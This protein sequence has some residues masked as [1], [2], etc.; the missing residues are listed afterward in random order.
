MSGYTPIKYPEFAKSDWDMS[1]SVSAKR[2]SLS[3]PAKR[4]TLG[5]LSGWQVYDIH[6][7]SFIEG[8]YNGI[9]AAAQAYDANLL[10][11]CGIAQLSPADHPPI[12]IP[13][14]PEAHDDTTFV[15]V[16]RWNTD[17]MIII[18]P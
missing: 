3:G 7:N 6:L 10:F 4:L 8:V 9:Q 14:W 13:A 2:M 11:A 18:S 15:P 17:G 16:G 5:V 12:I 1:N